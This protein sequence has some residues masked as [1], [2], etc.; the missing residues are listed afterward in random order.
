M[1]HEGHDVIETRFPHYDDNTVEGVYMKRWCRTC[2]ADCS[3]HLEPRR[4]EKCDFKILRG[5]ICAGCARDAHPSG[6]GL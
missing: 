4:C 5:S 2:R 1:N 6:G 3:I